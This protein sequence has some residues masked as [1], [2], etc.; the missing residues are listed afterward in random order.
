MDPYKV[1][2]AAFLLREF[3]VL[4]FVASRGGGAF[5]CQIRSFWS[6]F[7]LSIAL[8]NLNDYSWL[9][10]F[11]LPRTGFEDEVFVRSVVLV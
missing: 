3:G 5:C 6:L 8:M 10:N 9:V 2:L 7:S 4:F 1:I 11:R